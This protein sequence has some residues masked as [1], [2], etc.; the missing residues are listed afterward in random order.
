MVILGWLVLVFFVLSFGCWVVGRI[1]RS[2]YVRHS[3]VVFLG[4]ALLAAGILGGLGADP[5]GNNGPAW[6][7]MI[8]GTIIGGF[9]LFVGIN[10]LVNHAAER[11]NWRLP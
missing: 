6:M 11:S 5:Q 1:T 2:A 3:S 10:E 9:C 4:A 8:F 7:L